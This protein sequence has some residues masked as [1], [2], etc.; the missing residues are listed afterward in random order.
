MSLSS[1]CSEA[2]S[3]FSH[4][5]MIWDQLKPSQLAL[6]QLA[7]FLQDASLTQGLPLTPQ[8]EDWVLCMPRDTSIPGRKHLEKA[9]L[10]RAQSV[11][12]ETSFQPGFHLFV[13]F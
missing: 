2:P 8:G 6:K 11:V 1:A 9:A 13:T 12:L 10:P 4:E 7:P 5:N 3:T